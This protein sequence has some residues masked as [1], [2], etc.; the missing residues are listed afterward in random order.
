MTNGLLGGWGELVAAILVFLLSHAI[1][2]RP[3]IR[4]RL[5][6][7]FGERVYI[8]LYSIVSVALLAWLVIAARHAPFV[9]LWTQEPWQAH[10]PLAVM[11]L[12]SILLVYAIATPSPL[13]FPH[14]AGHVFDPERP[15]IAGVVRH[16]VL[17][18]ALLW[19]LAHMVPNGDLAHLILFGIF[20]LLALGG[21]LILD[22]RQRRLLGPER[23]RELAR[24]TSGLPFAAL[25]RGWRPHPRLADLGLVL[26]GLALYGLLLYGHQPVIGVS[27]LP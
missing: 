14:R 27:P 24:L 1:P 9:P 26:A 25:L 23:W 19:S 12:V 22:R 15:G 20:A 3:P 21:M 10:V 2:A 18:A 13:S 11:P 4:R 7:I 8:I 6:G 17:W 5:V 16:P